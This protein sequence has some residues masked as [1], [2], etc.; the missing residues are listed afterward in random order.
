MSLL[1]QHEEWRAHETA[2]V[3]LR[4]AE[5]GHA[6][7]VAAIMQPYWAEQEAY[8]ALARQAI[9]EGREP[10][11]PPVE[12]DL[13]GLLWGPEAFR[14][15][16]QR[17][18]DEA[19]ELKARFSQEIEDAAAE[20]EVELVDEVRKIA[21]QLQP[22]VNR[23]RGLLGELVAVRSA[24]ASRSSERV[25]PSPAERTRVTVTAADVL[26]AAAARYSLL[27]PV[28]LPGPPPEGR[29]QVDT[30]PGTPRLLGLQG[31]AGFENPSPEALDEL[32]R[33]RTS[34]SSY[35]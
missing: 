24:V 1:D 19:L 26:D 30:G 27:A 16:R 14:L 6:E 12:P 8:P 33:T 15:E 18:A 2:W 20:A 13:G 29:I 32:M 9:V 34:R 35:L 17:L 31:G 25:R 10:P 23:Y 28:A 22:V 3:E 11:A 21:A 7:R 5:K 4:A